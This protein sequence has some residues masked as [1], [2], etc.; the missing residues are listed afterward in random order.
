MDRKESMKMDKV[1]F[2]KWIRASMAAR[3]NSFDK[4]ASDAAS[5]A[6]DI[7]RA[8]CAARGEPTHY[9]IV[10]HSRFYTMNERE[11]VASVV[12]AEFVDPVYLLLVTAWND[13]QHWCDEV[14]GT[15]PT[16]E[17]KEEDGIEYSDAPTP[18]GRDFNFAVTFDPGTPEEKKCQLQVWAP[19][20]LHGAFQVGQTFAEKFATDFTIVPLAPVLLKMV[21]VSE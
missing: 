12:P 5:A 15:V 13:I 1:Q 14:E 21:K 3:E 4:A 2:A 9:C 8:E 10:D 20:M 7:K 19:N 6:M 11:A 16:V 18:E 17:E